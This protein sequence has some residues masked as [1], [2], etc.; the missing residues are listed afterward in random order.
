MAMWVQD[1]EEKLHALKGS[2]N[3]GA[4]FFSWGRPPKVEVMLTRVNLITN[5][6]GLPSESD[7]SP[8]KTRD[9]PQMNN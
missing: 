7:K 9:T 2:L 8:T 1:L 5:C 4:L 3:H 6:G